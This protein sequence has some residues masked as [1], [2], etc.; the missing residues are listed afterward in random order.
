MAVTVGAKE[1]S[2]ANPIGL[3]GDC[4]R[5]IEKFL[6][7]LRQLAGLQGRRLGAEEQTALEKALSYFR[8]AAPR[9]T[10]D[11][12]EDLFPLLA[13]GRYPQVAA[14]LERLGQEHAEAAA[15]HEDV[16][17]IG[18]RW[19]EA[20]ELQPLE[21]ARFGKLVGDLSGHY[22]G[23]IALEEGEIFP[24]AQAELGQAVKEKIGQSMAARRGVR[25]GGC[26]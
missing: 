14:A 7:V 20:G 1:N 4:H 11:E 10:A 13:G 8:E 17:A 6:G 15:W 16:N 3:M 9:H 5:R 26:P 22:E 23:H 12:E 24:L 25:Y 21:A 19:L 18:L 2:F